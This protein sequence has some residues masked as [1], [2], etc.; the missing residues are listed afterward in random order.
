M[1]KFLEKC[2]WRLGLDT[3]TSPEPEGPAVLPAIVS[4]L[5]SGA[6]APALLGAHEASLEGLAGLRNPDASAC[7]AGLQTS[8]CA[9][10]VAQKYL[11]LLSPLYHHGMHPAQTEALAVGFGVG[12]V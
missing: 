12:G 1:A 10:H 4:A 3:M 5:R 6:I 8:S 7:R 2:S 9:L 11:A